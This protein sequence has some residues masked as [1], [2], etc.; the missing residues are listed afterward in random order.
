VSEFSQWTTASAEKGPSKTSSDS[1]SV[2]VQ[3]ILLRKKL[4]DV[5]VDDGSGKLTVWVVADFKKVLVPQENWGTF[6]SG[7]SYV[8]LY[9]YKNPKGVELHIIYCKC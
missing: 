1:A 7:D 2:D 6:Y 5:P 9:S 4:E 8:L 3:A